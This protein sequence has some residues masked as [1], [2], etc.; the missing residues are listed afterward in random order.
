[1]GWPASQDFKIIEIQTRTCASARASLTRNKADDA[2]ITAHVWRTQRIVVGAAY[3]ASKEE[4]LELDLQDKFGFVVGDSKNLLMQELIGS[5][6]A[7]RR[8]KIHLSS[9]VGCN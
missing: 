1:M 6:Q 3:V 7:K 4:P 9:V 8:R 2:S 5:P